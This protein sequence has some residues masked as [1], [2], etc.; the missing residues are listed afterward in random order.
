MEKLQPVKFNYNVIFEKKSTICRLIGY[1]SPYKNSEQ[2][3][4]DINVM[5]HGKDLKGNDATNYKIIGWETMHDGQY[6]ADVEVTFVPNSDDT[7]DQI[8][9]LI[10][11]SSK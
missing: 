9:K 11:I 7:Y 6:N 8:F 5:L 3:L 2:E 4:D 1:N 10:N